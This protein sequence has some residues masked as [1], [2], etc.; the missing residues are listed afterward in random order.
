MEP[1]YGNDI[2]LHEFSKQERWKQAVDKGVV[3]QIDKITLQQIC[4]RNY[5]KHLF[6]TIRSGSYQIHPP[7]EALVPK[8]DGTMRTVYV[9]QGQDRIILSVIND[10]LFELCPEKIHPQCTSYKKGTG[11]GNVVKQVSKIIGHM[12]ENPDYETLGVK[13]DLSKYFDSVPISYIDNVF[14][15]V[16]EKFGK[17]SIIN[18]I[19]NYY[20]D[21]TVISLKKEKYNKYMSLRQGCAVAAF[22]ADSVLYG[23]DSTI[24]SQNVYYVRYSDDMLILGKEYPAAMQSM[25]KMLS[26]M[27]LALNP[28]KIQKLHKDQWFQFLGFSLKNSMISMSKTRIKTFQKEIEKITV[29][30]QTSSEKE[31][32]K[33]VYA[34]LYGNPYDTGYSWA[35]AVL[36][37]INNQ[38]D[39]SLLNGYTMDAIRA[40]MTGKTQIGGLGACMTKDHVIQ[41]GK[42]RHVKHNRNTIPELK[43]YKSISCMKNA[44]ITSKAAYAAMLVCK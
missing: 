8:D 43:W 38:K 29:K 10:M 3:K 30:K 1:K 25:E 34:Y 22:L 24:S 4:S 9:N 20:H 7:H 12:N 41:R 18:L 44:M 35:Q 13:L 37:I 16:E 32:T 19:R 39:I 6:D 17:S 14:D 23:I 11:C 40:G 33:A 42:G 31:I 21:D 28:R 2:L 36:P 27:N 26:E 15:Y 5:R